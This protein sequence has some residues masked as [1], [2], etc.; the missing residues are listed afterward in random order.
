[1]Q[2]RGCSPLDCGELRACQRYPTG[3]LPDQSLT[4]CL[5]NGY[6]WPWGFFDASLC[7]ASFLNGGLTRQRWRWGLEVDPI[8][9]G[10]SAGWGLVGF[11]IS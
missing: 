8:Y 3:L 4:S 5:L 11:L 2:V 1:M 10:I 7:V 9:L 6:R